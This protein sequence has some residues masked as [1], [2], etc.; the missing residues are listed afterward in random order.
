MHFGFFF[1]TFF[2]AWTQYCLAHTPENAL[3]QF[4]ETIEAQRT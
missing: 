3:F 1:F 4:S 2:G